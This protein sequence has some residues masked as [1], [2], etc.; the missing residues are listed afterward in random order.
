[1]TS[2]VLGNATISDLDISETRRAGHDL[3][4]QGSPGLVRDPGPC[5]RLPCPA[6][7]CLDYVSVGRTRA[8]GRAAQL[9]SDIS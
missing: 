5:C 4:R 9:R 2:L 1:M 3:S 6:A 7:P 8:V